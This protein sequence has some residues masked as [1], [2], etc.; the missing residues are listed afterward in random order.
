MTPDRLT[1]V[2]GSHIGL[3]LGDLMSTAGFNVDSDRLIWFIWLLSDT[4]SFPL[5]CRPTVDRRSLRLSGSS[6]HIE[7]IWTPRIW[8][9]IRVPQSGVSNERPGTRIRT[10]TSHT[11]FTTGASISA[12]SRPVPS[13]A[14]LLSANGTRRLWSPRTVTTDGHRNLWQRSCQQRWRGCKRFGQMGN[15]LDT[16]IP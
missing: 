5:R 14:R 8:R 7:L 12:N 9:D 15:I 2:P 13:Q 11:I 10:R 16:K 6:R 3:H 1:R 4:D